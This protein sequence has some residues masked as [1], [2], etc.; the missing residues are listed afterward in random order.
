MLSI[1]QKAVDD[2]RSLLESEAKEV[3]SSY[4]I[5][6]PPYRVAKTDDEA[7]SYAKELGYPVVMKILSPDILHKSDAGGVLL[8]I[9]NSA[10]ARSA[11]CK[12]MKNARNYKEDAKLIGALVS[13][14]A[15]QGVEVI[16]GMT[17]DP[18]F[19]P[20]IMFGLG[21]IFV[22]VFKDVSFRVTPLERKDAEDMISEIKAYPILRGIR[23]EKPKD[24][25]ALVD[26][27]LKVS[28]LCDDVPEIKEL[29]L[30]PI[31]L[32]EKGISIVDARII[33]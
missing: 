12:L 5:D 31:F 17:K 15:K 27:I 14:M 10:E 16:V 30:N 26:M 20:V 19:G 28:H 3:L 13:P 23:G 33:L 11:F 24:V 22:E 2:G 29:D 32:Y 9:K 25:G 4:G 8:N 18:Q 6:V 21:G 7:A 1:I